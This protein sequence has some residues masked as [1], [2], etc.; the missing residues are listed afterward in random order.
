MFDNFRHGHPRLIALDSDMDRTRQYII[1]YPEVRAI[2]NRLAENAVQML[3]EPPIKHTL[4]SRGGFSNR[5]LDHVWVLLPESR[6]C[7]ERI[8]TLATLYRLEGD[9]RFAQRACEELLAASAFSDWNPSH[10]LDTAEMTHAVAIGYDWLYDFMD[11]ETRRTISQAI[12]EKGLNPG[13]QAYKSLHHFVVTG[14]NWNQVCNGGLGIGALAVADE[15]PD[16]SEHILSRSLASIRRAMETYAPDGGW[17]EGPIYW[18]YATRYNVYFLQALETALGDDFGLLE[19]PGFSHTGD[20]RLHFTGPLGGTFNYSDS[21]VIAGGAPE[22]F[23]LSRKFNNTAY[24]W[25][26]RQFT[27]DLHIDDSGQS[28][29]EG[30]IA[31][32]LLWFNPD[33]ESLKETGGSLDAMFR[34]I[35]VVFFRSA[36]NDS[37]ALFVGFKG[38]EGGV[39]H[40]H[41]D[42]G[43]FIMEA[44]GYRWAVDLGREDYEIRDFLLQT[45]K[46]KERWEIYR[47]GTESHNTLLINKKYQPPSA[48]ASITRF[49]SRPDDAFAIVNLSEA[50][51]MARRV[52]R[53]IRMLERRQVLIQDE[54]VSDTPLDVLW[55]M[56]TPSKITL[57]TD[58]AILSQGNACLEVRILAPHNVNFE[59]IECNP[60]E[61]QKQQPD[62]RKLAVKVNKEDIDIRIVLLLTPYLDKKEI[63]ETIPDIVNL[64]LWE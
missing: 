8:Y 60:P 39:S 53:G 54:V 36:W 52:Q 11:L 48:K 7:V 27:D 47:L 59:I 25:H 2:R 13:V 51:P 62:I 31:H 21:D 57:Q 28:K 30:A 18:H 6:L 49:V 24:A 42:L 17:N 55:S 15:Q 58:V 20:F 26:Q 46:V 50:Y 41:M 43:S 33:G 61:P 34:K 19:M 32:D 12:V 1:R 56:L 10:F 35:D 4:L 9:E 45:G 64:A 22:M 3:T 38:G 29:N 40:G 16:L 23:W 63:P 14:T 37:N 5:S 44:L